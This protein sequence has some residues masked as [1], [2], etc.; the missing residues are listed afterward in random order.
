MLSFVWEKLKGNHKVKT[1]VEKLASCSFEIFLAH[2]FKWS[3]LTIIPSMP[4]R[5]GVWLVVV[6]GESILGGFFL[7]KAFARY[8]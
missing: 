5:Y 6:W 1:A 7:K 2:L 3:D 4:I 8:A